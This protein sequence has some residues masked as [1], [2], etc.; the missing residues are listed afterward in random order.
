MC[1]NLNEIKKKTNNE[2]AYECFEKGHEF[3]TK[4]KIKNCFQE[5]N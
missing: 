4:E 1:K 5:Q 2:T 3:H